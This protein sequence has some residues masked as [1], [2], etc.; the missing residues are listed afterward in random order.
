MP[1]IVTQSENG[2]FVS[3]MRTIIPTAHAAV[4]G[5]FGPYNFGTVPSVFAAPTFSTGGGGGV[6]TFALNR[7][8]STANVT[9]PSGQIGQVLGAQTSILPNGAPNAGMGGT[10]T[11]RVNPGLMLVFLLATGLLLYRKK[12]SVYVG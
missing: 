12:L 3:L 9:L 2:F 4:L 8:G 11:N 6:Q 5:N 1:A 10:S 7:G